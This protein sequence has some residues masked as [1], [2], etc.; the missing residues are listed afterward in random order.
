MSGRWGRSAGLRC[1]LLALATLLLALLTLLA[2]TAI[3]P[4]GRRKPERAQHDGGLLAELNVIRW[5]YLKGS[6]NIARTMTSAFRVAALILCEKVGTTTRQDGALDTGAARKG[7]GGA[8][9]HRGGTQAVAARLA[10][11]ESDRKALAAQTTAV[12]LPSSVSAGL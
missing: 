4:T 2:S 7:P 12:E 3:I 9:Q 8:R 1:S 11:E 10:R 6:D 5:T